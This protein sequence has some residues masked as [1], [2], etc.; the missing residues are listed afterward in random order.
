MRVRLLLA[1]VGAA[2]L[3]VAPIVV[4]GAGPR[5]VSTSPFAMTALC[6]LVVLA[7]V[8]L[9]IL[10]RRLPLL[11]AVVIVIALRVPLVFLPPV[12]SD[13]VYRYVH[14][15]R[16]GR[17][18]LD[19]PY[20]FAPAQIS[21]PFDD[22]ISSRINHK[23]VPAAYPP[24]TQLLLVVVTGIGDAIGA[25]LAALKAFL[26]ALDALLIGLLFLYR[27][28]FEDERTALTYGTHPLP[29]IALGLGP[30]LD[31]ILALLIVGAFVV[32]RVPFAGRAGPRT[33]AESH[34][35]AR[36]RDVATGF[37]VGLAALVKPI[38]LLAL[39]GLPRR[40]FVALGVLIGVAI[41]SIPYLVLGTPL[42]DGLLAYGS[43]WRAS[44]ILFP[45]FEALFSS[46]DRTRVAAA[47]YMHLHIDGTSPGF[48]LEESERTIV[49][50]GDV[51]P[52]AIRI[53]VDGALF[54]RL[55][56]AAALV[57]VVALVVRSRALSGPTRTAIALGAFLLLTP[58][59]HPWYFLWVLPFG[60]ALSSRTIVFASVGALALYS[61]KLVELA[62]QGWAESPVTVLVLLLS[63]TLGAVLDRRARGARA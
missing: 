40:A 11:A 5:G 30:H 46:W 63:L 48:L 19:V 3:V 36:M 20:R 61:P 31:G 42:L 1:V 13:D 50:L 59:L 7:C 24:V 16:G 56:S 45:L 25:P 12:L 37:L 60:A 9:A 32:S 8:G 54:A 18:A 14:E 17:I 51:G 47:V 62:G 41:P 10:L 21:L 2:L 43:R 15:G 44:P 53:L 29:L 34:S 27:H 58:T 26:L 4:V 22:D 55:L 33:D 6:I 38:A 39:I 28:R 49:K 23:D 57:V 52:D 35:R